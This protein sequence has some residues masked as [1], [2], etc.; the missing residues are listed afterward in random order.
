MPWGAKRGVTVKIKLVSPIGIAAIVVGM[1]GATAG[2]ASAANNIKPFG[3]Q[4]ALNEIGY[5]VKGLAPSSD[6]CPTTASFT[7]RL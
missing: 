6:P 7:Q 1:A 5:T 4:E 3:Q 2:P